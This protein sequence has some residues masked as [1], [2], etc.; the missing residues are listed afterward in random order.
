[1]KDIYTVEDCIAYK[2]PANC[3]VLE[4]KQNK[5]SYG[6]VYKGCLLFSFKIHKLN[7]NAYNQGIW[8][9]HILPNLCEWIPKHTLLQA[10]SCFTA[11]LYFALLRQS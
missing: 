4:T 10:N 9:L 7:Y 3:G 6:K 5:K 1:M 11:A 8:N 2:A